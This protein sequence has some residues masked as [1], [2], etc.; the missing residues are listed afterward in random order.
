[1]TRLRIA[2]ISP[3]CIALPLLASTQASPDET[4]Q[5]YVDSTYQVTLRFPGDWK[6][7]PIYSD[8][9]YFGAERRLH[10]VPRGYFQLLV[11]GDENDTPEQACKGSAE[12]VVQPFGKNPTVR[13]MKVQGES[14][15]LVWPSEDQGAPW[16]AE[17]VI[18]YPKPVEIN[19]DRYGLLML[20]ADKDYILAITQTLGFITTAHQ[21]APFLI[22]I[23]P[24]NAIK[25]G[26]A[27]WKAGAPVSVILTMKNTS[28]R[29]LHF[30]LT[31]PAFD[32]RMTVLDSKHDERVPVTE[33]FQKMEKEL[34]QGHARTRNVLITL[35]P[36]E[37]CQD[38][39]E[40][41]YFYDLERPGQYTVQ[42][43]RD[44]PPELGKGIV[45]SN[46]IRVTVI[47]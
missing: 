18:K 13:Q 10:T 30:A 28:Q 20:D 35:K 15:C 45:E 23:A 46:T 43:E 33:N 41:S 42:V 37:T 1:M 44:M 21:N 17:V 39:I 27:E 31:D 5:T 26:T 2:L 16:D 38:T 7:D 34:K 14:A 40:V 47:D 6:R 29:V 4:W 12:H 36:Q 11:M 9:P 3:F 25:P 22:E 19:G 8:R 32:Y 24:Q